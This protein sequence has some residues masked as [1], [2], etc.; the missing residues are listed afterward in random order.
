MSVLNVLTVCVCARLHRCVYVSVT[1][2]SYI[3]AANRKARGSLQRAQNEPSTAADGMS[4][5]Y[6]ALYSFTS[7]PLSLCLCSS[8]GRLCLPLAHHSERFHMKHSMCYRM[9]SS[10]VSSRSLRGLPRRHGAFMWLARSCSRLP[11]VLLMCDAK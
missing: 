10:A 5:S 3:T 11:A 6:L 1:L 4:L 9:C 7:P 8:G 2:R